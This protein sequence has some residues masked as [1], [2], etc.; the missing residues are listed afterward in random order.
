MKTILLATFWISVYLMLVLAPL[1]ILTLGAVPHG[2][3]FWWDFSMALGFSAM[4]MMSV[5]FILTARFKRA[6]APFGIDIIYYFHRYLALIAVGLIF[7][8]YIII[9]INNVDVLGTINPLHAPWYMTAGRVSFVLFAML[10]VTSLWRKRLRIHYDEWRM[11][12]IAKIG[13]AHV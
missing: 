9:R 12:H 7:L 4:A 2:S 8:H 3:G 5:Q 11:L 6:S 1:F 13:R 10:V